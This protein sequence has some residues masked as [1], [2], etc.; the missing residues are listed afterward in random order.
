MAHLFRTK[1][2]YLTANGVFKS[3]NLTD[4]LLNLHFTAEAGNTERE[5]R[6][7]TK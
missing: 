1:V 6:R 3:S 5:Q 4:Q 7:E 2:T